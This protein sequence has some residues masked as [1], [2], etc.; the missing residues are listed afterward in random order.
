MKIHTSEYF[1]IGIGFDYV[2][3]QIDIHFAL[4]CLEIKFNKNK[5][6]KTN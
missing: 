4:W 5:D 1:G 3:L 6:E 2:N